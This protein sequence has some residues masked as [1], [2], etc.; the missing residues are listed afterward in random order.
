MRIMVMAGTSDAVSIIGNLAKHEGI[1]VIA[2]TTTKYGGELAVNA[3]A[4]EII[5]G[6]L[7]VQEIVDLIIV[8]KIDLL[9]DATHPF[10]SEATINAVKAVQNS[11]IEY[12]RYERP[13]I[14]IPENDNVFEVLSFHEAGMKAL[15][16]MNDN[17]NTRMMYL[18][19]VTTLI[20]ITKLIKPEL[21]VARI[22]PAVYSIKKC[23]EIG[24][25][26]QNIIAMQGTFS[27]E[28]NK[29][30][31]R[32]Y[33]ASVVIT[34]ESGETG[35]THSKI[36]AAADLKIPIIIVKRP[37]IQELVKEMIFNDIDNLL[38]AVLTLS[39]ELNL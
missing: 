3:G 23:L 34:K 33:A 6:R 31:M 5:V 30:I 17:P 35:G 22:L 29:A 38:R 27:K 8:N 18:A 12:I 24:I 26:S 2:T 21:I 25:P 37:I 19:G 15:E 20:Q 9:I 4:D 39:L 36:A 1:E 28:F 32:E 14:K 7:G 13:S 16:F 10:A 11:G